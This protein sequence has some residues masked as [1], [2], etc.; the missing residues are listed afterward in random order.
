M[1]FGTSSGSSQQNTISFLQISTKDDDGNDVNSFMD[2]LALVQNSIKGHVLMARKGDTSKFFMFSILSITENSNSESFIIDVTLLSESEPNPF[3]TTAPNNDVILSFSMV[4]TKGDKGDR[5]DPGI[6][7]KG[8]QGEDGPKGQ[9]G[10]KG[11]PGIG[12]KGPHGERGPPSVEPGPKGAQGEPGIGI[13]GD[14]GEQGDRGPIGAQGLKGDAGPAGTASSTLKAQWDQD[15]ITSSTSP[16]T[17][18]IILNENTVLDGDLFEIVEKTGFRGVR[19]KQNANVLI[20]IM[21]PVRNNTGTIGAPF[22]ASLIVQVFT[23]HIN[24]YANETALDNNISDKEILGDTGMTYYIPS[25]QVTQTDID[26]IH[27]FTAGE[28]IGINYN[29]VKPLSA[30]SIGT[31]IFPGHLSMVNLNGGDMGP[32]GDQGLRGP[33]GDEGPPAF[34]NKFQVILQN[35]FDGMAGV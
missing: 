3:G 4:G 9:Q 31:T 18:N 15:L 23:L 7:I 29:I 27:K 21:A 22:E 8:P 13:K 25:Q 35:L 32:K 30:N 26:I 10:E 28:I 14:K 20:S 34:E 5:G 6:G 19:I 1:G 11:D 17:G 16:Y 33:Q 2:S 24:K 12:I